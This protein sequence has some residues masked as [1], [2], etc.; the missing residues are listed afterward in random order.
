MTRMAGIASS[1]IARYAEPWVSIILII[2]ALAL[3]V[4]L[5]LERGMDSALSDPIDDYH[6]GMH[7]DLYANQISTA[8]SALRYGL[9]GYT[10]YSKVY[11]VIRAG[12]ISNASLER[13]ISIADVE[14]GGLRI[15]YQ[16]DY[17]FV[18]YARV[19]FALFGYRTEGFL[20]LY[21]LLFS[22]SVGLY[23]Y[24]FKGDDVARSIL[25][26][27]LIAH[28]MAVAA[29]TI[30]GAQLETIY[31]FRFVAVLAVLPVLH[32]SALM[33]RGKTATFSTYATALAQGILISGVIWMRNSALWVVCFL[34]L[35]A[36]V[37][38]L[39]G[40][41]WVRTEISATRQW[42]FASIAT[43]EK[44]LKL[45]PLF[46]LLAVVLSTKAARPLLFHSEYDNDKSGHLFFHPLLIGLSIHPD[47]GK[48]Y[49]DYDYASWRNSAFKNIC[50]EGDTS[51]AT[52]VSSARKWICDNYKD[53]N[54]LIDTAFMAKYHKSNDQHGFSAAF[55]ALRENGEKETA[56]FNFASE[57]RI[58]YKPYFERFARQSEFDRANYDRAY[59]LYTDLDVERYEGIL[60]DIVHE[61]YWQ[62]PI[63]V[64]EL[65][66]VIRPTQILYYLLTQ[67]ANISNLPPFWFLVIT[68]V[69]AAVYAARSTLYELKNVLYLLC[70]AL[71]CSL[72]IPLGI[73][74]AYY[75]FSDMAVT[76]ML[77]LLFV[78]VALAGKK[79]EKF[80]GRI[81]G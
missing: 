72:I 63:Q 38:L 78:A 44:L 10:S 30:I 26:V 58:D 47:I 24:Q 1:Q 40:R 77:G 60:R 59:D 67:Y 80:L 70:S 71:A 68:L 27:Y 81:G 75:A 61:I 74:P 5:A 69:Y 39:V 76:L 32:L 25:A 7:N 79:T 51:R 33:L 18:D 20:Y 14:E 9:T 53:N 46:M 13:A 22:T 73:Y 15:F 31:S 41:P 48:R 50:S 3:T 37:Q 17:G 6:I 2:T 45:W 66:F 21:F 16:L 49:S 34:A 43:R 29:V 4:D 35:W 52:L 8:I 23:F 55:K 62:Y 11:D 19:S 28:Y 56:I 57:D 12:N 42:S 65:V 36:V 54:L 64:A